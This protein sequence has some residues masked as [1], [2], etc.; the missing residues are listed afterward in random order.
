M[1]I[2]DS[3]VIYLYDDGPFIN[4]TNNK[5]Y[6]NTA[7]NGIMLGNKNGSNFNSNSSFTK[8]VVVSGNTV[9][10]LLYTSRCV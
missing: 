5:L 8:N 2:R 10:C 4:V 6:N 9:T 1:C 7:T 3:A